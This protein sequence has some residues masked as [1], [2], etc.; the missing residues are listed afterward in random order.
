MPDNT[1]PARRS[2]RRLAIA[3][4]L[5]LF[6]GLIISFPARIAYSWFASP[7]VSMSGI[8]GSVWRGQASEGAIGG[9]YLTDLRWRFRPFPLFRGEAAFGISAQPVSGFI[10]ADIAVGVGGTVRLTDVT[11]ELPIR[12]LERLVAVSGLDGDIRLQMERVVLEDGMP[13]AATGV[14]DVSNLVVRPLSAA[15]LGN[16]RATLE[17]EGQTIRGIVQDTS[18]VLEV[19][20]DIELSPDRRWLLLGLIAARREAPAAVTDQLQYLGT[21]DAEGRRSFRLEGEL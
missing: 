10:D 8:T 21:A 4:A 11:A 12:S 3:G 5:T 7:A 18:G 14:V 16:Y 15:A 1:R 20:G 19:S 13:V 6:L 9:I 17:T 2:M